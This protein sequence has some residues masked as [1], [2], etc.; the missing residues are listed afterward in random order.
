[1]KIFHIRQIFLAKVEPGTGNNLKKLIDNTDAGI[2][3]MTVYLA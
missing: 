2:G 3:L 1:M